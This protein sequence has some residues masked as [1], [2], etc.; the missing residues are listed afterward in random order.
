MRIVIASS[1]CTASVTLQHAT[2]Q[3]ES[4]TFSSLGSEFFFRERVRL[5]FYLQKAK[6]VRIGAGPA[7]LGRLCGFM[8]VHMSL[9][10]RNLSWLCSEQR[11]GE[12]GSFM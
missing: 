3:I 4:W 10:G 2:F 7:L 11:H 9:S 8:P 5:A 1:P 6:M 12:R